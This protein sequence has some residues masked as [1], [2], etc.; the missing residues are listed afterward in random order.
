[1]DGTDI[2]ISI[3]VQGERSVSGSETTARSTSGAKQSKS[4]RPTTGPTPSAPPPAHSGLG[5]SVSRTLARHMAG[6]LVYHRFE[7][8]TTFELQLPIAEPADLGTS[9]QDVIEKK[10]DGA[11]RSHGPGSRSPQEHRLEPVRGTSN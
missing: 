8:I 10:Q 11:G 9:R 7:G 5:L 6:D 3:Q 2:T 4:S 1:M